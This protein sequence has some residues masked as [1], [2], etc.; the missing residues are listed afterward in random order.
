MGQIR[1]FSYYVRHIRKRKPRCLSAWAPV[2]LIQQF[3]LRYAIRE[4]QQVVFVSANTTPHSIHMVR[5]RSIAM[6]RLHT[7]VVA[8]SHGPRKGS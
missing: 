8:R 2:G 4:C 3:N 1:G 7:R 5:N 6:R